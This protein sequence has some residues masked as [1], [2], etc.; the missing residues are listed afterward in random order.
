MYHKH[1]FVQFIELELCTVDRCSSANCM[2]EFLVDTVRQ[3]N[4]FI[5][6]LLHFNEDLKQKKYP[7]QV[8]RKSNSIFYWYQNL[9]KRILNMMLA[10]PTYSNRDITHL[11]WP[12]QPENPP[13]RPR[14]RRIS[15]YAA[16]V[17]EIRIRASVKLLE[18]G[19]R[20][21]GGLFL[22][23]WY[24]GGI[25]FPRFRTTSL[26]IFCIILGLGLLESKWER[27]L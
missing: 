18:L 3:P 14:A 4:V 8:S 20:T 26:P 27:S 15:P 22:G 2:N 21:P 13:G 23:V 19:I 1:T 11:V 12:H 9:F 5:S 16:N 7:R 17:V 25:D 24:A 10:L 6:A